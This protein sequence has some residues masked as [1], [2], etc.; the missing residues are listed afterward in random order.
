VTI[1][2]RETRSLKEL[3]LQ[4][5]RNRNLLSFLVTEYGVPHVRGD[6]GAV[7]LDAEGVERLKFALAAHDRKRRSAS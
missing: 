2:A 1:A 5:R 7:A 6:R 3:G 4:L